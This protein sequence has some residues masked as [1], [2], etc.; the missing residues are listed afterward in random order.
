MGIYRRS[1]T[2]K[3]IK[4][5]SKKCR[6]RK[7][8]KDLD[9]IQTDMLPQNID[10]LLKDSLDEELPGGGEFLCVE[11]SR[12]FIDKANL[13]H[14]KGTKLHK[15]RVKNLSEPAYTVEEANA[16]GGSG[17][18]DFYTKRIEK[19]K[20]SARGNKKTALKKEENTISMMSYE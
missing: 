16:A 2:H 10:R 7:R 14:H 15:K 3:G 20:G 9:Q 11:C 19:I 12:H 13:D 6:L 4:D 5:I 1:R 18:S 8:T 17:S